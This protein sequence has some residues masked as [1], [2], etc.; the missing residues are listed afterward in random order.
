MEARIAAR[1]EF[2][3]KLLDAASRIDVLQLSSEEWVAHVTNVHLQLTADA[4]RFE[5]VT[6]TADNCSF[7]VFW[8]NAVLHVP[9]PC[10]RIL[11]KISLCCT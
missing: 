10:G 5:G 6:T 8:V 11:T 1:C 9:S 3:L 2:V 7:D 4:P